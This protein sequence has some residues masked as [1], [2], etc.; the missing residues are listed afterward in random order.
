MV[1]HDPDVANI[2]L[3]YTILAVYELGSPC[4]LPTKAPTGH[5]RSHKVML[6]PST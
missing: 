2:L 4:S 1:L 3:T 5:F 6:E